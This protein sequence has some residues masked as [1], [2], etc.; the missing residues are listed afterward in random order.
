MQVDLRISSKATYMG[1]KKAEK[2][3][4]VTLDVAAEML[5]VSR[6]TVKRLADRGAI[7][8]VYVTPDSPRVVLSDVERLA[9]GEAD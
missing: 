2:P 4:L 6:R 3:L 1:T 9:S 5:G 7:R 8:L